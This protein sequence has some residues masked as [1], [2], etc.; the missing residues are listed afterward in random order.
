V[1]PYGAATLNLKYQYLTVAFGLSHEVRQEYGL[2]R[3]RQSDLASVSLVRIFGARRASVTTSTSYGLNRSPSAAFEDFRYTTYSASLGLKF[4][5]N[6]SL[7]TE[8][9]YSYFR[10]SQ[11]DLPIDSHTVFVSLAYRFEPR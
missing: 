4:P 6:R 3:L 11:V 5:I 9:G 2:G 1:A 7:H 8:G 10:S